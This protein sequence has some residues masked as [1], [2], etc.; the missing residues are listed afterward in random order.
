MKYQ[1]LHD[2]SPQEYE[3]NLVEVV[4]HARP[5]E[6]EKLL[7]TGPGGDDL[8]ALAVAVNPLLRAELWPSLSDEMRAFVEYYDSWCVTPSATEEMVN[9]VCHD[10]TEQWYRVEAEEIVDELLASIQG[11]EGV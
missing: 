11:G 10:I 3:A 4:T 2:I 5:F 7:E 9:R 6:Y 8:A 1:L